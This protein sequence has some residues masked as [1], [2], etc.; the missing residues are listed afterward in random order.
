MW[1]SIITDFLSHAQ[2]VYYIIQFPHENGLFAGILVF[3]FLAPLVWH[4]DAFTNR[5]DKYKGFKEWTYIYP[6][7]APKRTLYRAMSNTLS[8]VII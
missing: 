8:H 7:S 4:Y 5:E 2:D 6:N 1:F 3:G